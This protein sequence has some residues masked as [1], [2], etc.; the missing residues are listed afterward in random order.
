MLPV[1]LMTKPK[2]LT[3]GW[4]PLKVTVIALKK[5]LPNERAHA[6]GYGRV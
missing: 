3:G 4:R 2:K 6:T 5:V 1:K